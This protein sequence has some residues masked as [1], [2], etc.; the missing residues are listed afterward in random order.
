MPAVGKI[1]IVVLENTP[2]DR[3]VGSPAAPFLNEL[4]ARGGL[5]EAYSG[6][7]RPS[8]PNYLALFSG[9]TQGVTD[10]DS[11]D[12]DAPNLADQLDAARRTW[13]EYAEN[14]PPDCFTGSTASGGRDGPG[15][16]ARKHAPAISFTSIRSDA[17]RCA[18]IH[19]LTD[20][21]PGAVDYALIVPNLCHDMHSCSI[22]AGDAW[23]ADFVPRITASAAFGDRGLLVVTFDEGDPH[24][25]GND[26]VATILVSP[27]VAA[28]S[29]SRVPHDHYSLFRTVQA[30]W[31]LDCLA[32]SCHANTLAELFA[33]S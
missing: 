27:L 3:I 10:N 23:L 4:I 29:R 9:S 30:A 18:N 12:I 25:E 1:W 21:E 16:Y 31:G 32:E 13:G 28:G 14:V 22:S 2:Y 8:Q 7:G 20:F 17:A 15:D 24:A 33:G 11:H 6:V 26:R 19:D 5:A